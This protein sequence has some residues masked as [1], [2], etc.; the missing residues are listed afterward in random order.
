MKVHTNFTARLT[1]FQGEKNTKPSETMQDQ[2]VTPQELLR[3]F[4]T[5]APLGF[6]N[7]QPVY[8]DDNIDADV[9]ELYKM[10]K[11]ERLHAL[12]ESTDN[13][14]EKQNL[15]NEALYKYQQAEKQKAEKAKK[16]ES[17]IEKNEQTTK[18]SEV[19]SE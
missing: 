2:A 18:R 4:A 3:R 13:L 8:D 16:Q 1:K 9:P 14:I 19:T 6:K 11:M 17:T 5:G 7:A 12:Q 15:H 10:N